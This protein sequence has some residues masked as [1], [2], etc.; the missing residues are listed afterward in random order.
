MH[1]VLREAEFAF[2]HGA[3]GRAELSWKRRQAFQVSEQEDP[4]RRGGL[5]R[6]G[7]DGHGVAEQALALEPH[8]PEFKSWL[9]AHVLQ[10]E[11]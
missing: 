11:L 7:N 3:F 6:D 10:V 4:R 1:R 8:G 2:V 5:S 9:S